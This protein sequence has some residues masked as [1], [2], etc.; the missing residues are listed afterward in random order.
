MT[1]FGRVSRARVLAL[2]CV[3]TLGFVQP[4]AATRVRGRGRGRAEVTPLMT[5][6]DAIVTRAIREGATPGAALAIGHADDEPQIRTYGRIDWARGAPPVT[7]T[8]L[9]D[10]ASVTKVVATTPAAMLLVQSGQ[11]DLDQPVASY[12]SWWPKD[13]AKGRITVR[14]LLLHTSGLPAGNELWRVDGDREDRIRHIA[15]TPLASKPGEVT[16]YSDLGMI[17]LGAVI[18]SI[19]HE[20]LDTFVQGHL[21]QPLALADTRYLP[22]SAEDGSPVPLDRIAPT[23]EARG[24]HLQG[25]VDD[26]NAWALGGVAGHA[27]LF[28]S[29][30]DLARFSRMI[31]GAT[32]GESTDVLNASVIRDFAADRPDGR[33]ALGWDGAGSSSWGHYFSP[34]SF[35]HNGYTGTSIWIDP[36][37]DLYVVLLT[38]RVDPSARNEKHLALRR[39]VSAAVREASPIRMAVADASPGEAGVFAAEVAAARTIFTRPIES[40]RRAAARHHGRHSRHHPARAAARTRRANAAP[41]RGRHTT[42]RAGSG[43]SRSHASTRAHPT[44]HRG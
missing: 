44:R 9:Y 24:R 19:T 40:L 31:L 1:S 22:L 39:D 42:A 37:R 34:V 11:L 43:H 3:C 7:E 30:R 26:A 21:F 38:N 8:T 20:R 36:E 27:G 16:E 5:K 12:L 13:G 33:R 29:I 28:S 18:E 10:L 4:V 17:L 2:V 15:D 23:E 14:Q 35:G 6:L 32:E 41:A 25:D